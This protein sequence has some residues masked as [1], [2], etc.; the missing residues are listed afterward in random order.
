MFMFIII[1]FNIY[2]YVMFIKTTECGL[3]IDLLL[4]WGKL[5][6]CNFVQVLDY[7]TFEGVDH[8]LKQDT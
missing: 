5:G 2:V 8:C 4:V 3:P 7:S 1:I 6:C